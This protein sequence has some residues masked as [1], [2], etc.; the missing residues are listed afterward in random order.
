MTLQRQTEAAQVDI[1]RFHHSDTSGQRVFFTI[2][3]DFEDETI[4]LAFHF[5]AEEPSLVG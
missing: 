2:I 4:A 3:V 1:D 5:V